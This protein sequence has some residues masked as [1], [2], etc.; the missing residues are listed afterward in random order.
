[1]QLSGT[2]F[3]HTRI[4]DH[5]ITCLYNGNDGG[6]HVFDGIGEFEV[7]PDGLVVQ[8]AG[9]SLSHW[10]STIEALE[11]PF[12]FIIVDTACFSSCANY[13]FPLAWQ[14]IV[15]ADAF[16]GWHGGPAPDDEYLR[17]W[18][19]EAGDG[20]TATP[21]AWAHA[22]NAAERTHRLYALTGASTDLLQVTHNPNLSRQEQRWLRQHQQ[23]GWSGAVVL[24]PDI[25]ETCFNIVGTDTMWHPGDALATLEA[26]RQALG[27]GVVLIAIPADRDEAGCP[28]P[29]WRNRADEIEAEFR[30]ASQP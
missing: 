20:A 28:L 21:E 26:G 19:H 25:L 16:V 24:P 9:G 4:G 2:R 7:A 11:P 29:A 6:G 18:M 8:S 30:G 13:A 1:M 5:H 22:R 23:Q 27:D 12:D 3:A 14:K 15:P 10:L 17:W